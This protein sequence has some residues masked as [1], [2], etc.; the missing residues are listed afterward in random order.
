MG[1][2]PLLWM[3]GES[4]VCDKKLMVRKYFIFKFFCRLFGCSGFLRFSIFLSCSTYLTEKWHR[5]V[6]VMKSVRRKESGEKNVMLNQSNTP[7]ERGGWRGRIVAFRPFIFDFFFIY[8]FLSLS[9][10]PSIE[11]EGFVTFSFCERSK[12]KMFH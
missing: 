9:S 6:A 7:S 2:S 8:F 12:I 1:N 10:L 11:L 3:T 4:L 5:M